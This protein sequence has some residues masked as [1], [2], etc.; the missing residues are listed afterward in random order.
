MLKEVHFQNDADYAESFIVGFFIFSSLLIGYL[1]E[2]SEPY[3]IPISC[4]ASSK[5][6]LPIIF[7]IA[8][9]KKKQ[10]TVKAQAW[11]SPGIKFL[12]NEDVTITNRF[13]F[14][15]QRDH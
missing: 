8:I 9:K 13:D 15:L 5:A 4:L 11:G 1:C 12:W 14:V 3:W 6:L 7:G 10:T 2:F